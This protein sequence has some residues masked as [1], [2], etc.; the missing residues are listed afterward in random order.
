M[1][2]LL[3]LHALLTTN[4]K[5]SQ[6]LSEIEFTFPQPVQISN[7]FMSQVSKEKLELSE[8]NQYNISCKLFK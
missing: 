1:E 2:E 4:E 8:S 7:E 5:S 3:L 6:D